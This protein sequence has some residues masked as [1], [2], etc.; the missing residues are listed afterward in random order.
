MIR[1][2]RIAGPPEPADAFRRGHRALRLRRARSTGVLRAVRDMKQRI[3]RERREAG[4][5]LEADLKEGPGGIRDVEFT[6]Q[7]LQLFLGGRDPALRTGNVLDALDALVRA[8]ALPEPTGGRAGATATSGSAAPSTPCSSPRSGRRHGS[9][10]SPRAA[11]RARAPH[12]V[13]RRRGRSRARAARRRLDRGAGE[14]RAQFEALVLGSRDEPALA[15]D[16]RRARGHARS[17]RAAHPRRARSSRTPRRRCRGDRRAPRRRARGARARFGGEPEHDLACLLARRGFLARAGELDAGASPSRHAAALEADREEPVADLEDRLDTMRLLRREEIASRPART[18][19]ASRPSSRSPTC[20]RLL[21]EATRAPR[22]TSRAGTARARPGADDAF[23][24]DRDGQDRRPRVHLSLRP[25]SDLP[26]PRPARD[27]SRVAARPA[28]DRL[29]HDE[30][31]RG[32]RVRGR[33]AAAAVGAAGHARHLVRGLRAL[34]AR[35]TRDLG[36]PRAA[37]RA[38]DRGRGDA[39]AGACARAATRARRPAA[40]WNELADLRRA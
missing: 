1:L 27:R 32:H 22:S 40:P 26:V 24:V 2:R 35:E 3:E 18:S 37:A 38:P 12:G 17:T 19:A 28:P 15:R 36:A 33:H 7:A 11:H 14:V 10:A 31:R 20:C 6:V 16:R 30:D 29:S 9:R 13:S 5:D 34:P 23:A 39:A 25:R 4:R 8:G 21:A